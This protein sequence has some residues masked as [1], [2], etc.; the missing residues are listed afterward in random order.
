M[1]IRD[2]MVC[3]T[4]LIA[5]HPKGGIAASSVKTKLRA[6]SPEPKIGS[7]LYPLGGHNEMIDG[8]WETPTETILR[9]MVEEGYSLAE[10]AEIVEVYRGLRPIFQFTTEKFKNHFYFYSITI[11]T[12]PLILL[13]DYMEKSEGCE[14]LSMMPDEFPLV[15]ESDDNYIGKI[16]CS[17]IL[18]NIEVNPINL[19]DK[20]WVYSN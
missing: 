1:I 3:S 10:D 8:K 11:C 18:N 16:I 13:D 6:I 12:T 5:P 2:D 4:I 19:T 9:E 17:N 15:W 7:W 20:G 14:Q